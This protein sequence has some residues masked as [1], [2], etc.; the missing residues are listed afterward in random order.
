MTKLIATYS[1]THQ[2][3]R[4]EEPIDEQL[5]PDENLH[6]LRRLAEQVEQA[7]S[8]GTYPSRF[9]LA[10]VLSSDQNLIRLGEIRVQNHPEVTSESYLTVAAEMEEV[11]RGR[12]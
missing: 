5:T 2:P 11:L 3:I 7:V 10:V 4:F 12:I 9:S 1:L 6:A 8:R